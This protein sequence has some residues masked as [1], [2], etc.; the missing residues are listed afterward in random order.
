M[1]KFFVE[2]L[3]EGQ[4]WHWRLHMYI[5]LALTMINHSNTST[6]TLQAAYAGARCLPT[7]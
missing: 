4:R 5:Y 7:T 3:F 6:H 2:L 1:K